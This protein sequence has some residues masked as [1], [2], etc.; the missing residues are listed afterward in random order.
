[1]RIGFNRF[2]HRTIFVMRR[3][4]TAIRPRNEGIAFSYYHR[5]AQAYRCL[6]EVSRVDYHVCPTERNGRWRVAM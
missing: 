3:V 6:M 2:H 4:N 5:R 1:M